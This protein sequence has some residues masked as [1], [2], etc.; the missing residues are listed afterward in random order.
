MKIT[1]KLRFESSNSKIESFGNNRY[2]VYL[3]S[4]KE[5]ADVKDELYA[6]LSRTLGVPP[7]RI[8]YVGKDGNGDAVFQT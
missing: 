3:L 7:D 4:S 5:D 8:E 6:M 2:L 1:V